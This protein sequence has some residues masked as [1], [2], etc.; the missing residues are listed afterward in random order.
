MGT[1]L[2]HA[3]GRTDKIQTDE[4]KLIVAFRNVME[5]PKMLAYGPWL[6]VCVCVCVCVCIMQQHESMA[7]VR[8]MTQMSA[9]TALVICT[10]DSTND[11]YCELYNNRTKP[12][13]LKK[14]VR[15]THASVDNVIQ[16]LWREKLHSVHM[17]W[18]RDLGVS[19]EVYYV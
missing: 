10:W 12:F 6:C 8:N 16:Y 4:T 1:T 14:L 5:V 18:N 2:F 13:Q 15:C 3:D 17:Q 11:H 9:V 19:L 7:T